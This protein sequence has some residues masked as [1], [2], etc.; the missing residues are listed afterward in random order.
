MGMVVDE[1]VI[2]L[3]GSFVVYDGGRRT[4]K[5]CPD[6]SR[7]NHMVPCGVWC[8]FLEVHEVTRKDDLKYEIVLGC[9]PQPGSMSGFMVYRTAMFKDLRL[10]PKEEMAIQLDAMQADIDRRKRRDLLLQK[11]QAA[12]E[13]ANKPTLK[14][15]KEC[16]RKHPVDD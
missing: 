8:P 6:C 10:T 14:E 4:K 7:D 13:A 11:K 3:D 15:I 16:D 5:Y 2:G 9:R 12:E 1:V